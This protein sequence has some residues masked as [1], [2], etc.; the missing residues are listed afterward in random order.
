MNRP[1]GATVLSSL[2][3]ALGASAFADA[4]DEQLLEQFVTHHDEAA[5][6][7][8]LRRHGPMVWGICQRLV[9]HQQDAEDCFQ[10][11]FLVLCR[12]ANSIGRSKLLANWLFGVARRAALNAQARRGRRARHETA[13]AELPDVPGASTVPWDDTLSV[14]DDELA[15]LPNRYRLPLIL[16]CLEGM[17][18]AQ[19]GASLGWPV[20]TVA[21]RLSRGRE[22]LRARLNRRGVLAPGA[23]LPALLVADTAPANMPAHLAAASVRSAVAFFMA[24]HSAP[25][26]VSATVTALVRGVLNKM[27]LHRVLTRSILT[28]CAALALGGAAE[29]WQ[30]RLSAGGHSAAPAT[31]HKNAVAANPRKPIVRLP[32]DADAVVLRLNRVV[33]SSPAASVQLT[34]FADGRV[35]AEV[36]EGLKSLAAQ[37]LT[38]YARCRTEAGKND[39]LPGFKVLQGKLARPDLEEL[40]RFAVLEQDFLTIDAAT[41]KTAIRRV[42]E[43]DGAVVDTTD[44]TTTAFMVQTADKK[45][46]VSWPR[47]DKSAWDFPEVSSLRQLRALE[48][49]LAHVY[50]VLLAGGP[51]RVGAVVENLDSLLLPYYLKNPD[52]PFLTAADLSQVTASADGSSTRYQFVR[53]GSKFGFL[54]R[55]AASIV[56]PEHGKPF[57]DCVIPPQ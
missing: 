38:R 37:D 15:R 34:I 31:T 23:V 25:A 27:L 32:A 35:L 22:M 43:S 44:T 2:R 50:Y 46:Q 8:L 13:C 55:F 36:P 49:K 33:D 29:T 9:S 10:A 6:A 1:E 16:C 24:G 26:D 54:P 47:L 28:A 18:H 5:F 14:L 17:T 48:F 7:A 45:N 30:L 40:M 3:R 41:V 56:V 53:P 4:A 12:K 19:A 21:G 52:V 39:E 51:E 11:T 57:L 20:G 42:Y